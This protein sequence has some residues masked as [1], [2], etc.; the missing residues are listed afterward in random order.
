MIKKTL[1]LLGLVA[2]TFALQSC[3][4]KDYDLDNID[5]TVSVNTDLTVRVGSLDTIRLRNVMDLEPDGVVQFVSDGIAGSEDSIFAIIQD[6]EADIAPIKIEEVKINPQIGDIETIVNLK[7]L[8]GGGSSAPRRKARNITIQIDNPMGGGKIPFTFDLDK[9]N[10]DFHYEITAGS[11]QNIIDADNDKSKAEINSDVIEIVEVSFKENTKLTINMRTTGFTNWMPKLKLTD[12]SLTVPTAL[13]LKNFTLKAYQD[14]ELK[15]I[16]SSSNITSN[17]LPLTDANGQYVDTN[18]DI[19]LTITID[20][21]VKDNQSLKFDPATHKVSFGGVFEVGGIFEMGTKDIDEA[22]LQTYL[23]SLSSEKIAEVYNN[24]HVTLLPIMPTFITFTGNADFGTQGI[25]L[26]NFKGK[27]QHEIGDIAP[28]KLD[29]MPDFLDDPSVNL[30]LDNPILLLCAKQGINIPV[31]I[32]SLKLTATTES[33]TQIAVTKKIDNILGNSVANYFYIADKELSAE[34]KAILV[35]KYPEYANVKRIELQSGSVKALIEKIPDEVK[36]EVSPVKLDTKTKFVDIT[37]EYDVD[38]EYKVFAPMKL[39]SNFTLVYDDEETGWAEDL[40]DLEDLDLDSLNFSAKAISNMPADIVLTLV[41]IA[42]D[43]STINQL[44][45]T[46]IDVKAMAKNQDV[47]FVFKPAPGYTIN[48]VLAG[49]DKKGV[50]KLDGVKYKAEIK[51]ISN[52]DGKVMAMPQ[53]AYIILN[54]L[55]VSIKGNIVYD[56]N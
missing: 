56:A 19:T 4:D 48:D 6:G 25:V 52:Y 45:V 20:G 44:I 54:D 22:K 10:Q 23:S 7:E 37:K 28:L 47:K 46:S 11:A 12:L 30:D 34:D 16:S 21:A 42:E 14:G 18:K 27:L 8:M 38:I 39:G 3:F 50:K 15:T 40:E 49:N 43:K 33:G 32:N 5:K 13:K 51:G 24:E 36:I 26:K 2:A 17:V 35:A 31:E 9:I 29:D 55:R 53:D 1:T 41:P